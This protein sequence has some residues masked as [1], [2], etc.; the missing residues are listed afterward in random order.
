MP[1]DSI[2]ASKENIGLIKGDFKSSILPLFVGMP[3]GFLSTF[4]NNTFPDRGYLSKDYYLGVAFELQLMIFLSFLFCIPLMKFESLRYNVSFKEMCTGSIFCNFICFL[5]AF[6]HGFFP[7]L[8]LY[9]LQW[10]WI[11]Y[12]WPK[13]YVPAFRYAIWISLGVICGSIAGTIVGFNLI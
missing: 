9:F 8:L 3:V 4:L 5:I 11:C 10:L 6:G 13:K 2:E 12:F 1:E 7:L